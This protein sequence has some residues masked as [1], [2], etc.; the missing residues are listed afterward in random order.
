[1]IIGKVRPSYYIALVTSLWGVLSMSQGF[2]KNF[3]QLAALRFLL[4]LVE[5]P[6]LPAV[7]VVM[8]CWYKRS[9][10]PPRIAILYGGN[11]MSAAFSGLIAA[12]ITSRMNNVGGREAW[13]W[14]FIIEGAITVVIAIL[15]IPVLTDYPLQSKHY[16]ISHELQLIGVSAIS[17]VRRTM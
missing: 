10:L 14:L 3:S 9:E 13:S 6:F 12:G 4:G 8:S 16:F 2:T 1:M 17:L 11:M 5:A 7:F 15:M